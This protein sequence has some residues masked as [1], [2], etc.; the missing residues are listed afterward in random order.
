MMNWL[1]ER[2]CPFDANALATE[3]LSWWSESASENY[4]W[5]LEHGATLLL[6]ESAKNAARQGSLDYLQWLVEHGHKI[7]ASA[8]DYVRSI[9]FLTQ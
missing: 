7:P 4:R 6:E 5:A 8:L 1:L 3:N 9:S 2:Q